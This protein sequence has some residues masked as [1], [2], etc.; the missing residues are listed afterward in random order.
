MNDAFIRPDPDPSEANHIFADGF[1]QSTRIKV[2]ASNWFGDATQEVTVAP[3]PPAPAP[4][5]P[6]AV[7]DLFEIRPLMIAPNQEVTIRWHTTGATRVE[8]TPVGTVDLQGTTTNSPTAAQSYTL[9]AFNKDNQ[10]TTRTLNVQVREPGVLPIQLSFSGSS[11]NAKPNSQGAIEVN[12]GDSVV[13]Q[14]QARNA[15]SVR[16]DAVS[17]VTLQGGSGFRQALI[18]GEGHY[19]F[20]LVATDAKGGEVRYSPTRWR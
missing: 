6:P 3:K 20:A 5:A 17:P 9:T 1:A 10:P 7:V 16:I 13:F 15:A 19:T 2:L 18:K 11:Q 14:W 8:L 12:V 4:P